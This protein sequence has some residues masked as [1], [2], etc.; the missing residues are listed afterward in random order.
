MTNNRGRGI[1]AIEPIYKNELLIAE[2][3]IMIGQN[4]IQN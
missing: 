3:A 4:E 2:K 1:F